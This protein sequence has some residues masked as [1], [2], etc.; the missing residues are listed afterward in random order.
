MHHGKPGRVLAALTLAAALWAPAALA[1][2]PVFEL[3]I[4]D[5][6]FQPATLEVPANTR[7]RLVVVNADATPEEFESHELNREKVIAG[8]SRATIL[9]GP[10]DA[11]TYPFV[12]EFHEDTAKGTIVVR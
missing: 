3:T 4:R 1:E 9:I 2:E 5:H 7:V 10:L 12:G 6:R 8:N 11:G